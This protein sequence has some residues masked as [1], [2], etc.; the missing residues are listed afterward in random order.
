MVLEPTGPGWSLEA[1]VALAV[2]GLGVLGILLL[3]H[4][5]LGVSGT[6]LAAV[7]VVVAGGSFYGVFIP[8]WRRLPEDVRR[9]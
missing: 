2:W 6:Q 3:A 7:G 4:S 9:S 8:L 1:R 5:V